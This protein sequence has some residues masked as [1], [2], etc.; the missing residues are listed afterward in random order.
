LLETDVFVSTAEDVEVAN[1]VEA[2][3]RLLAV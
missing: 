3:P 1:L 2:I